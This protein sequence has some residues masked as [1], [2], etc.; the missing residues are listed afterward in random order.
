MVEARF[1]NLAGVAAPGRGMAAAEFRRRAAWPAQQIEA[2]IEQVERQPAG[3][4]KAAVNSL[5]AFSLQID[6]QQVLEGT[7]RNEDE[8]ETPPQVQFAHVLIDQGHAIPRAG[9]KFGGFAPRDGQHPLGG[10]DA[11]DVEPGGGERERNAPG[12]AGKLENR[13]ARCSRQPLIK[14]DIAGNLGRCLAV[15]RIV[16]F[17]EQRT[18]TV[19]KAI[20]VASR[21]AM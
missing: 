20:H 14:G 4:F 1:Q 6:R 9:R 15:E 17:Y 16:G 12:A 10:V 18:G 21:L 5:K 8:A 7:K 13:S 2:R 11:H 3:R 19:V